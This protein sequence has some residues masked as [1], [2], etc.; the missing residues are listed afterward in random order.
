LKAL[1]FAE[2]LITPTLRQW[3][4]VRHSHSSVNSLRV[5]RGADLYASHRSRW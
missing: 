1:M 3:A 4:K 2:G 5:S